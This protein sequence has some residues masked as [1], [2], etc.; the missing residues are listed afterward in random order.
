VPAAIADGVV[1]W[2]ADRAVGRFEVG[3]AVDQ[4]GGHVRVVAAGREVQRGLVAGAA[5]VGVG[6]GGQQQSHDLGAVG[7]VAGPVGH[8]VQRGPGPE[9]AA[10][11]RGGQLGRRG[12]EPADGVDV[13]HADGEAQFDRGVRFGRTHVDTVRAS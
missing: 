6:A 2:A 8:D 4:S 3:A 13:P 12:D 7:K 5:A 9:R 11:R 1:E 10:E